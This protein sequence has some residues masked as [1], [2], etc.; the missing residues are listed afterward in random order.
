MKRTLT[1][2]LGTFGYL[3]LT[4][5]WLW[6]CVTLGMPLIKSGWFHTLFLPNH[7]SQTLPTYTVDIPQPLAILFMVLAVIFAV[8]MSIYAVIAVP[9]TIAKTG[10]KVT[11]STARVVIPRITHRQPISKKREKTLI[12]RISWSAKFIA[13][14]IPLI[15]AFIPISSQL[16]LDQSIVSSVA[17]VCGVC[18]FA[19]FAGQ[20]VLARLFALDQRVVW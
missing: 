7:S 4:M 8:G 18:T 13:A 14:T 10:K 2:T 12:E 3:S 19:W 11:T 1:N 6:L 16:S 9:K 15:A 5:Q 20:F 17:I